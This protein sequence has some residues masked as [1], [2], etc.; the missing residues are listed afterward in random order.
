MEKNFEVNERDFKYFVMD[1]EKE[2]FRAIVLEV[3]DTYWEVF[4]TGGRR[5]SVLKDGGGLKNVIDTPKAPKKLW[6]FVEEYYEVYKGSR[7]ECNDTEISFCENIANYFSDREL[8]TGNEVHF[9]VFIKDDAMFIQKNVCLFCCT[10]TENFV[11]EVNLKRIEEYRD[12][13]AEKTGYRSHDHILFK[14]GYI[15]YQWECPVPLLKPLTRKY[16]E[17]ITSKFPK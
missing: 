1:P 10:T 6:D 7:Y 4:T 12:A 5:L 17:E 15:V 2:S 11:R 8:Q 9:E 13:Y 14:E 16:A 3:H